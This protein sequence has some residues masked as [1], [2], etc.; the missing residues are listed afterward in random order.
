[1]A[2]DRAFGMFSPALQKRITEAKKAIADLNVEVGKLRDAK[3]RAAEEDT[4]NA[5]EEAKRN[6]I[7]LA[8]IGGI[9]TAY[10]KLSATIRHL[11]DAGMENTVEANRQALA[12]T[13]LGREVAAIFLPATNA[14]TQASLS[15]AKALSK[16]TEEGQNVV[17]VISYAVTGL[18]T[19]TAAQLAATAAGLKFTGVLA[20]IVRWLP[21]IGLAGGA[22]AALGLLFLNT[23][24]GASLLNSALEET[25][26]LLNEIG[27]KAE[28]MKNMTWTEWLGVKG[29]EML[30]A[31][32]ILKKGVAD[33]AVGFVG[34]VQKREGRVKKPDKGRREVRPGVPSF[35]SIDSFERIQLAAAKISG[36]GKDVPQQQLDV[37]KEQLQEFRLINQKLEMPVRAKIMAGIAVP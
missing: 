10:L 36:N 22:I 8:A 20:G 21:L 11:K 33:M 19:F 30:E 24:S 32:G 23:E 29:F 25:V 5:A 2:D 15:G 17:M 3:R 7:R 37:A 35:G 16:L 4:R 14:A 6:R 18:M 26:D 12:Y 31:V 9:V 34:D 28:T 1:M 27:R 13:M